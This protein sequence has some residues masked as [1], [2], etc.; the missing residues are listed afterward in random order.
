MR[1]QAVTLDPMI[2]A[3]TLLR[4]ITARARDIVTA[5]PGAAAAGSPRHIERTDLLAADA[6]IGP[7]RARLHDE[8]NVE[9]QMMAGHVTL[10][11]GGVADC[12]EIAAGRS[13]EIN[14]PVLSTIVRSVAETAGQVLWL[15]EEGAG[16]EERVRRLLAWRIKDIGAEEKW[17]RSFDQSNPEAAAALAAIEAEE[18]QTLAT[19]A[20]AG[21][22]ANGHVVDPKGFRPPTLVE[23]DSTKPEKVPGLGDFATRVTV[24]PTAYPVLS[25]AAHGGRSGVIR[26]M[27]PGGTDSSGRTV[28]NMAGDGL[29][30]NLAI[31]V[32]THA[33]N[34][35]SNALAAWNGYHSM[36]VYKAVAELD[37][38]L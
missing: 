23:V 16:A 6:P 2:E 5:A 14:T 1:Q 25:S 33:L 36:P 27:S 20:A 3:H 34:E 38:Y 37:Q 28:V 30:P 11:A 32:T 9:A 17:F 24:S 35:V 21:W 18:Q 22:Q 19:V 13:N 26:G 15:L 31:K 7:N 10:I 4:E 8:L 29:P 12:L